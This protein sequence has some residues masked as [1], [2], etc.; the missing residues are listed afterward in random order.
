MR[1]RLMGLDTETSIRIDSC[2]VVDE[3]QNSL[4]GP[5]R[6]GLIKVDG[7]CLESRL[8]R[9]QFPVLAGANTIHYI[10]QLAIGDL[11]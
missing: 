10:S 3:V 9:Q 11:K 2:I 7:G 4:Y 1:S 6:Q 5:G 8:L